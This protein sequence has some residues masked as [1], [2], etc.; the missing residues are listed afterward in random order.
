MAMGA[1]LAAAAPYAVLAQQGQAA[2]PWPDP[3]QQ[4]AFPAPAQQNV[5]PNAP[6][7]PSGPPGPPQQGSPFGPPQGAGGPPGSSPIC[8]QFPKLRDEAQKKVAIVQQ[9]GSHKPPDRAKMCAAVT[10]FAAAEGVVVKFLEANKTACGVPNEAVANAKVVHANTEKFKDQVCAEGP[11]PKIPTLSDAIST[12]PVD[13]PKNTKT[14][15]GTFN[16]LTGNPLGN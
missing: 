1:A 11:K 12:A 2:S 9:I 3:P 4:S 5:F 13:T 7:G 15:P 6:S 16:T 10:Q 8:A 14:G